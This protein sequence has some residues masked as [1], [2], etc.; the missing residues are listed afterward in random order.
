MQ[1][2]A[3]HLIGSHD[4]SS[5]RA[6]DCQASTTTREIFAVEVQRAET[7][8][9]VRVHG[10]AFLKNMVRIV[11][12][13]LSEVGLGQYDPPWVHDVLVARDRTVAGRT[14]P[15]S[16]LTLDEVLYPDDPWSNPVGIG[17]WQLVPGRDA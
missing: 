8:I 12:G 1:E 2:A 5:F 15:A 10:S 14:A 4:F 3:M 9:T 11:V 7:M 6:S 13:T 16:G 17:S